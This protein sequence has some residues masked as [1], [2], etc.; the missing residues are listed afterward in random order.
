VP[1]EPPLTQTVARSISTFLADANGR[2][3]TFSDAEMR[4]LVGDA[5]PYKKN[6]LDIL[7]QLATTDDIQ[8]EVQI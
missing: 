8:I 1:L 4:R 3:R 5:R 2:A 7:Y 6:N